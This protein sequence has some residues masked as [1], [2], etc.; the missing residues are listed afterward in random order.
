MNNDP[1]FKPIDKSERVH[2]LDALRGFA[3]LGILMINILNFSGYIYMMADEQ[4]RLLLADWNT[5]FD[6]FHTV[7]FRGKFYTLFSLLFGIGFAIQLIRASS[8]GRSFTLHFNRRLF[9]LLLIGIVHLWGIWYGDILVLYALCGFL[10]ILFKDM[11]SRGLLW[12]AFLILLIP[13]LNAW[14]IM[15][16][17]GVQ[18]NITPFN[19]V[20]SGKQ[21]DA[22]QYHG[23][24]SPLE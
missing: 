7:L 16:T 22:N 13:G 1:V 18:R 17:D 6:R 15:A 9:F 11:P 24:R 8:A 2:V 23:N 20:N 21:H 12:A 3:I 19:V 14:Y 10:L 5:L 4:N